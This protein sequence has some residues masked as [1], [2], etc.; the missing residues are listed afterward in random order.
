MHKLHACIRGGDDDCRRRRAPWAVK[1]LLPLE[2]SLFGSA[3]E[4]AILM[5]HAVRSME[6]FHKKG[7]RSPSYKHAGLQ[8]NAGRTARGLATKL[9][10]RGRLIFRKH[11]VVTVLHAYFAQHGPGDFITHPTSNFGVRG[12]VGSQLYA[13]SATNFQCANSAHPWLGCCVP[14]S[15]DP[16]R[17]NTMLQ[18]P[19]NL[20]HHL[21]V[22]TR[23][24]C[25]KVHIKQCR[26][27]AFG[28]YITGQKQSLCYYHY[29]YYE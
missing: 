26:L 21:H 7:K 11:A 5:R 28:Q 3:K 12:R 10:H 8:C 2:R 9:C 13:P 17:L 16:M 14:T 1:S 4:L 25:Q 6:P 24:Y 20:L 19:T 18:L 22:Q 23:C 15:K 29:H 27:A